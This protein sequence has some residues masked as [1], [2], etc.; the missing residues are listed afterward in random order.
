[1]IYPRS[2]LW[3][4]VFSVNLSSQMQLAAAWPSH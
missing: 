1:M 3:K 4:L 2:A